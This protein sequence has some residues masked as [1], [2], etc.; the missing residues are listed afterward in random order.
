MDLSRTKK[1]FLK[2][3]TT[4]VK[5]IKE[6]KNLPVY[7]NWKKENQDVVFKVVEGKLLLI[8]K[9]NLVGENPHLRAICWCFNTE[10]SRSVSMFEKRMKSWFEPTRNFLGEI[11]WE[12]PA[13]QVQPI[14]PQTN[15]FVKLVDAT[16]I[17]DG[18]Y[19][20]YDYYLLSLSG[21]E[22]CQGDISSQRWAKRKEVK[23]VPLIE[24]RGKFYLRVNG[25]L[26][27]G[28]EGVIVIP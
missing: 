15:G 26:V 4:S 18:Y 28:G 12:S 24:I 22:I 7:K 27:E 9:E 6:V 25:D 2:G 16:Y 1:E 3:S 23:N 19:W 8:K 13:N 5:F 11:L 10:L 20:G 21:A 17:P 14:R